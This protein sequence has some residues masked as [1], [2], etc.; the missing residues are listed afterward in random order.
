MNRSHRLKS[1]MGKARSSHERRRDDRMY[2]QLLIADFLSERAAEED[3]PII[4]GVADT[5]VVRRVPGAAVR[6]IEPL[7]EVGWDPVCE[8]PAIVT[9]R[10]P[11]ANPA[12]A[13]VAMR[14]RSRRAGFRWR[15]LLTGF[16]AAAIP[17]VG[18]LLLLSIFTG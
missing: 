6:V 17:G 7:E 18:L 16:L 11:G 1:H 3:S 12:I 14:V 13:G 4:H 5:R 10:T 2:E 9:P 8:C 15:A